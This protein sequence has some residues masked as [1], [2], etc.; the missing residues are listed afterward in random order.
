MP[1]KLLSRLLLSSA[2]LLGA[3]AV[4]AAD[5]SHR[6]VLDDK[7]CDEN[8]DLVADSPTD[9]SQWRDPSTLVF[10]YT[11]VEDPAVY[12]DAFSDFQKYLSEVTGKKVI[13]YTVHS[14]AAEVEAIRSGRLH[15]AGFSTGPTGYAVN[16]GGYVPIAVKGFADSFQ[17]YNLIVIVRKD[18]SIQ[19]M[20][21]IK[22]KT[23]AHTSASSNSGNLAPRAL[24]P[25]QGITPDT[26][27]TVKYSG[28]HDQSI[29]GVLSGDYDAAPVASDVFDRMVTAGR[30]KKDDFRIIYT[31]PRF[32]TSS[33]GYAHDLHPDLVKKIKHA[34]SSFRFPP[35]MQETF[36]GTD[37]FY[38]ITYQKDWQ[39]IRD[40]AHATGTAYTKTGLKKL[41]EKDAAKAAKKRAKQLAAEAAKKSE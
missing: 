12:K 37:R 24:F 17:G 9:P 33:F 35:A 2:L 16:L 4:Q 14:N 27:Y 5:C 23:V 29:M 6:G 10:T 40:I 31:S 38:P 36:N 21:D 26:D 41:A 1:K 25:E 28:K 8:K 39:V 22:G 20:D 13:Y 7:F 11:P 19:A 15:I 32:P 30:I 18:S 34:F 3:G